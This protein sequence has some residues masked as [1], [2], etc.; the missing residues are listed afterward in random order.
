[1]IKYFQASQEPFIYLLNLLS[2]YNM[3][4]PML[5]GIKNGKF[6]Q[7]AHN[8]REEPGDISGTIIKWLRIMRI[9]Q[10]HRTKAWN[11][12]DILFQ[13]KCQPY[14]TEL[15]PWLMGDAIHADLIIL[16]LVGKICLEVEVHLIERHQNWSPISCFSVLSV[17][18]WVCTCGLFRVDRQTYNLRL[19]TMN[20][21]CY[22]LQYGKFSWH[23]KYLQR[24]FSAL[25][26]SNIQYGFGC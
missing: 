1:M 22:E 10:Q 12:L 24:I 23:N 19:E 7:G 9:S 20:K 2:T 13:G 14:R 21:L 15:L 6:S 5:K 16:P 3:S 18:Y 26:T 4:C 25:A 17:T 11:K 8:L